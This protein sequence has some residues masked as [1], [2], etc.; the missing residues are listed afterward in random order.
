MALEANLTSPY[1][2]S[3]R[4]PKGFPMFPSAIF[5]RW[6]DIAELGFED[7]LCGERCHSYDTLYLYI[8]D[9][10]YMTIY[11]YSIIDIL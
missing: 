3:H 4:F 6:S 8:Y 1:I 5:L 2:V 10:I 11:I 9:N 7:W